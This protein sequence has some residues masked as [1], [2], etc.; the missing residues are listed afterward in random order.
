[1]FFF[2]AIDAVSGS[3]HNFIPRVSGRA[4]YLR[5]F[6][7]GIEDGYLLRNST[8]FRFTLI[9]NPGPWGERSF[10]AEDPWGNP[11]CFVEEGTFY[12]G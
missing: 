9:A 10:Y 2:E 3:C 5:P 12:R 11:L 6:L 1:V 7:Y 8:R 4:L